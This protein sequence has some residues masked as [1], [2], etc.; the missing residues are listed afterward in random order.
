MR[1]LFGGSTS[2]YAMERV[3]SQLLI[4]PGATGS[5]WDA[6]AGGTQITDLTDLAGNPI[7]QV[8]ADGEGAVAFYGPDEVTN[9][10][11]DFEYGRRYA[12]AAVDLGQI[13]QTHLA[14]KDQPGG[15]PSLDVNGRVPADRL[16][17]VLDWIF[18]TDHGAIGDGVADDT[19]AIKAAIAA[20]PVGGVVYFPAGRYKV[21]ATLDLPA[22]ITLQGTHSNLMIG[23][24]MTEADYPCW[25]EAA[26]PFTGS[27]ILQIIGDDDGTH[28]AINGEQRLFNLM[29]DGSQI[30]GSVDG[31]FA[32]GNVQNVVMRDFCI[33]RMPNNGIATGQNTAG[34]RPY[35]WRLHS[36]MINRCT[37]NGILFTGNTDL[38]LDDVQVLGCQAQ[39][40]SLTNCTNAQLIACRVEW[41]GSHGYRITGAWGNWAGS[42]GMQMTG[43]STDRC[44]QHG[45]FIDATGNTP[46]LIAGL[47]TR[48][49]GRNG[50]SGGGSYAGLAIVGATVPVTVTGIN[51]Y[52]GVDDGG[53]STN[54]PQYGVRVSGATTV[55]LDSA[56]LH[57]ATAGLYDDGTN[58]ALMVGVNVVTVAGATGATGRARVP[59]VVPLTDAATVTPD[60][61]KGNFFR[62]SMA[63]NRTLANPAN[64]T[65]GQRIAFELTASGADRTLTLGSAFAFGADITAISATLS[66]KTD[67][68]AAV[69]SASASK[70][71]VVEYRKGY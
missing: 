62:W 15:W 14:E 35:S 70:W 66:G 67:Y 28:P 49:D 21:S 34:I 55:Q 60:A 5:I 68:L 12:A 9:V 29:I 57:A 42:G 44:G 59:A 64:P 38:T 56:Y 7:S 43:C 20:C 4:R 52:P 26:A 11:M 10:F 13:L 45:V 6:P 18:V 19:T 31:L 41:C 50:G 40:I 61:L 39:G 33:R 48:R 23:P 69:Y 17:A 1:H 8:T 46:I 71:R 54:S 16:P 27:C 47:Q 24:G 22:G 3:G 2:D 53:G 37:S 30:T 65:D 58:T 63:G 32:R 25:I 51:C 36:V